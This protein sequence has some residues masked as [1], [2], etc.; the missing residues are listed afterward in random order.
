MPNATPGYSNQCL[1]GG[2]VY[3][4]LTEEGQTTNTFAPAAVNLED[5]WES[6]KEKIEGSVMIVSMALGSV[7]KVKPKEKEK[8][9]HRLWRCKWTGAE[10]WAL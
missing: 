2:N 9:T 7:G 6:S 10:R 3:K 8:L 4:Q 5:Y 1:S